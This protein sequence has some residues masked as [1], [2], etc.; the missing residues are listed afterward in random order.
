MEE[1]KIAIIPVTDRE[2]M[3]DLWPWIKATTLCDVDDHSTIL[4]G[5]L[6]GT[7]LMSKGTVNGEFVGIIVF[8][9]MQDG[10]CFV[11]ILYLKNHVRL[12]REVFFQTCREVGYKRILATTT[13]PEKTYT[14]LT[15]L[16]K[17]YSVYEYNL[18][19]EES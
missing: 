11:L 12:F 8:N 15:G 5:C 1:P 7:L 14:R 17:L 9:P 4:Q 13:I 2:E 19:E 16:K 18:V 6:N 3:I 10:T